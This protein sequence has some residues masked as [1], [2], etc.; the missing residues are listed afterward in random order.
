MA[1]E[2]FELLGFNIFYSNRVWGDQGFLPL[3][4]KQIT[5]W[6]LGLN[7]F[8]RAVGFSW[9]VEFGLQSSGFSAQALVFEVWA[10]GFRLWGLGVFGC[11]IWALGFRG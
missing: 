10:L 3:A 5:R 2:K 11:R 4:P 1:P 7:I 8:Y 9:A 6:S